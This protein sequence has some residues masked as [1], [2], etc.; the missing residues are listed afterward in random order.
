M[1]IHA[2][3]GEGSLVVKLAGVAGGVGLYREEAEAV[4]AAGFRVAMVDL[5]GDRHDDPAPS[6]ISWDL[7]A[8]ETVRGLDALGADRAIFW[9]TSF[10]AMTALATA[11][12]YPDRVAG[13]V[14]TLP[15]DPSFRPA[16]YRRLVAW[17]RR[18]RNP[19]L[20]VR[21]L[22]FLAF[23]GLTSW[24]GFWPTTLRRVPR[25]ARASLEAATPPRTLREKLD[26]LWSEEPGLPAPGTPTAIVAAARD[27]IA[28]RRGAERWA[29]R[30]PGASLRIVRFAGHAVPA[31]RPRAYAEAVVFGVRDVSGPTV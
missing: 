2:A 28:P 30:I 21:V 31:S 10:G 14:L 22:F 9:G 16:F 1:K 26:L 29:A 27:P 3:F 23:V 4:A 5:A 13:L 17:A 8:E 25:L 19:D 24:E 20:A 15:P 18:R 6:P 7:L 12:R 11:A